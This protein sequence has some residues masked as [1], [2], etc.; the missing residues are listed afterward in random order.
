MNKL[1]LVLL[2]LILI[3]LI[4]DS[5][6]IYN[7]VDSQDIKTQENSSYETVYK[8]QNWLIKEYSLYLF[9]VFFLIIILYTGLNF[10][11]EQWQ[12]KQY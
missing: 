6:V 11:K 9:G 3:I 10:I 2:S 8:S 1:I 12:K 5:Y 7:F 4:I